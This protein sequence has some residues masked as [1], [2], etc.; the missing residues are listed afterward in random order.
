MNKSTI[1]NLMD[2]YKRPFYIY[3]ED[4]IGEQIQ[5]LKDNFPEFEFLYSIKTNPNENI[6][7]FIAQNGIGSDAASKN[8]VLKDRKSTRLNSSH[9]L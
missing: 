2:K 5:K 7:K 3:D 4:I 6:V 1:K 9:R 8:E